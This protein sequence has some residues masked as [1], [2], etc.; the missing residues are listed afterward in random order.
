MLNAQLNQTLN[1]LAD[2]C[3]DQ[4]VI[5]KFACLLLDSGDFREL[6]GLLVLACVLAGYQTV[7][8]IAV[9]TGLSERSVFRWVRRLR[10]QRRLGWEYIPALV[11][12]D[13]SD[14]QA[15]ELT[16]LENLQREDLTDLESASVKRSNATFL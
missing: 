9:A 13:L 11:T 7:P 16:M 8:E 3:E 12:R 5:L 6:H 2:S 4:T 1:Q 14:Q 10:A 15:A